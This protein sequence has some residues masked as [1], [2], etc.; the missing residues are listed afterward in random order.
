MA[1]RRRPLLREKGRGKET[2]K[3]GNTGGQIHND[4]PGLA[5]CVVY[6]H[7]AVRGNFG[8]LDRVCIGY[9]DERGAL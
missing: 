8:Y 2:M 3:G 1:A 4:S 9:M 5:R 6:E 7:T